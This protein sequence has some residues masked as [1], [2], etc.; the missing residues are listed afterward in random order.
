MELFSTL[1]IFWFVI[2]GVA[3]FLFAVLDGFDLGVG[4]LFPFFS[5]DVA[6]KRTLLNTIWPV[7]DG[8]ELWG[9]IAAGGTF[10]I[11]PQVFAS[12]LSLLYPAVVLLMVT[13]MFRP[14]TFEFWFHDEKWRGL[15]EKVFLVGSFLVAFVFGAVVGITVSGM[16]ISVTDG[17]Q[18][19]GTI[20]ALLTPLPVVTGLLMV[21]VFLVHGCVYLVKKTEGATKAR[22]QDLLKKVWLPFV[23]VLALFVVT[24]MMTRNAW[25]NPVA[26][27]T[28]VLAVVSTVLVRLYA[29]SS[30]TRLFLF[31]GATIGALIATVGA[32]QFFTGVAGKAVMLYNNVDPS[33]SVTIDQ[34]S[35]VETLTFLAALGLIILPLIAVYAI[36]VYRAFKGKVNAGSIHY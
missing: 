34:S 33:L 27:V 22:A 26:W 14:V 21:A 24:L 10:A 4:M 11:F 30:E 23:I 19:L 31:S 7:W 13:L 35:P 2:I 15:W 1:Q 32:V 36:V 20:L 18:W 28:I 12:I 25:G 5:K 6:E 29:D 17:S 9:L 8:N 16:P 3:L